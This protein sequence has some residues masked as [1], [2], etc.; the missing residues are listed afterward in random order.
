M[1]ENAEQKR[2]KWNF[3]IEDIFTDINILINNFNEKSGGLNIENELKLIQQ[4]IMDLNE[5]IKQH[6]K[7][8]ESLSMAAATQ[9]TNQLENLQKKIL[10]ADKKKLS[11]SIQ[12]IQ[13]WKE[14]LLPQNHLHERYD[15]FISYYLKY[16]NQFVETLMVHLN[17][18]NKNLKVFTPN[19]D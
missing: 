15:N 2:I 17:P 14:K 10:Q 1:D 16:G 9:I 8:Y 6:D 7:T 18:L 11:D 19:N 13:K 4:K 3:S 12:Q 5:I